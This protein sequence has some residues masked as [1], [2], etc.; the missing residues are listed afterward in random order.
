MKFPLKNIKFLT[1]I[2]ALAAVY[3]SC[4]K[5]PDI[6]SYSYPEPEPKAIY[7]EAGYAGF[8]DVTITGSQ[9]GDYKNAVKVF[10]NGIQA[11]TIISCQD[12]VIVARVPALAASG[13]VSLQVWTHMIDS[14]ANFT[15]LPNPVITSVTDSAGVPGDEIVIYGAHFGSDQSKVSIS[16][17]GTPGTINSVEDS[18]VR[19]AVPSNFLPGNL[20]LTVNDFVVTGPGFGI[21]VAIPG[22]DYA[23]DF[24]GDLVDRISKAAATYNKGTAADLTWE[25][26]QR[27]QAARFP[28]FTPVSPVTWNSSGTV[29]I[30]LTAF[31]QKDFTVT[32]W[33]NWASGRDVYPDPIFEFGELR[34]TRIAFLTRMGSAANSWNGTARKMVGRFLL[35][36]TPVTGWE[37][38]FAGSNGILLPTN[39]WVHVAFVFSY[40][41]LSMKIYMDG[42]EIGSKNIDNAAADP[43]LMTIKKATV[44]GA[45][46]GSGTETNYGGLMDN[47]RIYNRVLT[48][49]QIYTDYYKK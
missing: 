7:P 33:L 21:L 48:A 36:K 15:V 17:N 12:S 34:D 18:M 37:N 8:A 49:D 25:P 14:V 47:F 43:F 29:S 9:F 19:V 46:Y 26:G 13:K 41:N 16:F 40:S 35:N 1:A 45:S 4:T 3:T 5:G 30:P 24:D 2:L 11:D 39:K 6:K 22:P 20:R 10:F 32:C 27:G 28:G 38:Y 31:K 44:G 23:L 42:K